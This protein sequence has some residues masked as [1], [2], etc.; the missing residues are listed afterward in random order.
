MEFVTQELMEAL[1]GPAG[2]M[3]DMLNQWINKRQSL[4]LS[5]RGLPKSR[6]H[7]RL[8]QVVQEA[9]TGGNPGS[10][11]YGTVKEKQDASSLSVKGG[12]R[13]LLS[14]GRDST[15]NRGPPVP[16]VNK[17]LLNALSNDATMCKVPVTDI[18]PVELAR[19][20][21]IIVGKLY[22]EIPYLEL[23]GKERPN[24]SKMIQVSNKITIWVTDTIVDEQD[25]KKRIGVVK[26]W[27]EVGEECLKLNNFDTLTAISCAIESTPV[28]RL[29]N[30]WDGIS[31]SYVERS[32][33]LRKT[34]SSDL[35]YRDYRAKLKTVQAP[36]IPFLGLYLTVIAYIEDGNSTYKE[37][38]PIVPPTPSG[39]SNPNNTPTTPLPA[40]ETLP[41]RKLLRYGRFF[42]LTKAVQEFRDFQGAYELLE[43]PR[44][45]D[46]IL[47]CMENQDSERNYRKSLAIEPRRPSGGVG[48]GNVGH[49]SSGG[50]GANGG[51]KGLFHGGI[52]HSEVH[53]GAAGGGK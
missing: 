27:I 52:S 37:L 50:G 49:R 40:S 10:N 22:T 14:S 8:H 15:N 19:Q 21:T 9:S 2:R 48:A 47:K 13:G 30:T 1:P 46:Y 39:T 53:G 34:I 20:L 5:G 36:C 32:N 4:N 25:V 42:Q 51:N 3:L 18:K 33:Q 45:R 29:N 23:L 7:E 24:C 26:H 17:A 28:K 43:V 38:N 16:L 6:S 41:A 44:L 35:N 11:K 12:R 31:K